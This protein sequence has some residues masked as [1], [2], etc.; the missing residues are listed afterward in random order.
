M[1]NKKIEDVKLIQSLYADTFTE[2]VRAEVEVH[3]K[4]GYTVEIAYNPI[5]NVEKGKILFTAL[6]TVR[7]Q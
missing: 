3:Q 4:N 5:F 6:L 1:N 7:G 2:C